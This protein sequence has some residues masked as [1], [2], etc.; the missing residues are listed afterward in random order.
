M[1]RSAETRTSFSLAV[2][3]AGQSRANLRIPKTENFPIIH[4]DIV[5]HLN[6]TIIIADHLGIGNNAANRVPA[7]ESDGQPRNVM[8]VQWFVL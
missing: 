8:S 1:S 7:S 4:C 6:Q 3:G 5:V 2:E